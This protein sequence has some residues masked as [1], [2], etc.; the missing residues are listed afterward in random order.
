MVKLKC[1]DQNEKKKN[2][3]IGTK[4]AFTPKIY[5]SNIISG[6]KLYSTN[7][8]SKTRFPGGRHVEKMPH[9]P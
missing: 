6:S 7:R 2:Q 8:V 3:N 4:S 1:R 9:Q 5:Y